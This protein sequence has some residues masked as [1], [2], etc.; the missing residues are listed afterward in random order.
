MKK[1]LY[2][3]IALWALFSCSQQEENVTTPINEDR[4]IT[5]ESVVD[6]V[7]SHMN[8]KHEAQDGLVLTNYVIQITDELGN[9]Q[10]HNIDSI[11]DGL[12]FTFDDV[13]GDVHVMVY[14]DN[15]NVNMNNYT[16]DGSTIIPKKNSIGSITME[17]ANY[18]YVV[19]KGPKDSIEDIYF[20]GYKND[21]YYWRLYDASYPEHDAYYFYCNGY[22]ATHD[23]I[24]EYTDG[25]FE[26]VDYFNTE[27]NTQYV[28]T[29]NGPGEPI[30]DPSKN[31]GLVINPGFE[32]APIEMNPSQPV[33]LNDISLIGSWNEWQYNVKPDSIYEDGSYTRYVWT[34]IQEN[35]IGECYNTMYFKFYNGMV[36]NDWYSPNYEI[37][38]DT[39]DE[40]VEFGEKLVGAVCNGFHNNFPAITIPIEHSG[41]Y[42]IVLVRENDTNNFF[43]EYEEIVNIPSLVD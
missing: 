29:L 9:H 40:Y 22:T 37:G 7:V 19:I 20:K 11:Y 1:F 2:S 28:Y 41:L 27:P 42:R 39:E 33:T 32:G 34:E 38:A 43:V 17:N 31:I 30:G 4:T 16:L 5:V 36:G 10:N 35:N 18:A 6:L 24:V 26:T 15:S 23:I 12:S 25:S 21:G 3:F 14:H 8:N 13:V